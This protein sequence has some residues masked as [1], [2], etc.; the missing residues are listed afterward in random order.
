VN[1]VPEPNIEGRLA[2]AVRSVARGQR[3]VK[4]TRDEL[5]RIVGADVSE[6]E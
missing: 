3:T 1:I 6:G 4:L 5:G 2:T